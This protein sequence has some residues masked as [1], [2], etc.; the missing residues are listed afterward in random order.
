MKIPKGFHKATKKELN[1]LPVKPFN[2]IKGKAVKSGY[3]KGEQVGSCDRIDYI[4]LIPDNYDEEKTELCNEILKSFEFGHSVVE[5]E[6]IGENRDKYDQTIS[7]LKKMFD[8]TELHIIN[9]NRAI[10]I[11]KRSVG[12]DYFTWSE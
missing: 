4:Y 10:V 1:N 12:Y 11:K 2:L 6:N 8:Y 7:Q 5:I 9:K 3:E